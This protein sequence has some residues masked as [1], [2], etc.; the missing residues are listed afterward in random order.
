MTCICG[1]I[2]EEHRPGGRECEADGCLCVMYE[3]DD[4]DDYPYT[5]EAGR[6]VE[7]EPQ[8][9]NDPK[10]HSDCKSRGARQI[11]IEQQL[12]RPE[13]PRRYAAE[14]DLRRSTMGHI[15]ESELKLR[16][17]VEGHDILA[18]QPDYCPLC[19]EIVYVPRMTEVP[20]VREWTPVERTA[21]PHCGAGIVL[22]K[23]TTPRL[24]IMGA[25]EAEAL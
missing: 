4:E 22:V 2:E 6:G 15:P 7:P 20:K 17:K 11:E 19:L 8:F 1:H 16:T 12:E 14:A 24:A 13:F 9:S 3:M 25:D 21:C 5:P 23:L 18:Y 10:T